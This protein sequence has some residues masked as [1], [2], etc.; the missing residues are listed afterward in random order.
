MSNTMTR[1]EL[2]QIGADAFLA[3]SKGKADA[4]KCLSALTLHNEAEGS[5]TLNLRNDSLKVSVGEHMTHAIHLEALRLTI[6][7][8][9]WYPVPAWHVARLCPCLALLW[10]WWPQRRFAF[11]IR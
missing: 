4:P 7:W 2:V 5:R 9:L 1:R 10:P 6:E 8:C 11:R 3:G